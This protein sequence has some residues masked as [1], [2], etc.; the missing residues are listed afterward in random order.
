MKFNS[1]KIKL[2]FAFAVVS[3]ASAVVGFF[4]LSAVEKTAEL[5]MYSS[6]NLAPSLDTIQHIRNRFFRSSDQ[7]ETAILAL[8]LDD[9]SAIARTHKDREQLLSELD[10]AL[11]KYEALPFV[12]EETG[13]FGQ[14]K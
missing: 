5:L 4:G 11:T 1:L 12:P 10:T 13:P 2:L 8:R 6:K 3:L 7:T 9:K 14:M